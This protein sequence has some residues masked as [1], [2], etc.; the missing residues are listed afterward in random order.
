[1]PNVLQPARQ[2]TCT[3]ILM[4]LDSF[5]IHG[6]GGGSGAI[7]LDNVECSG[8]EERLENCNNSGTGVHDFDH[9]EDVAVTC[10]GKND[11]HACNKMCCTI[12]CM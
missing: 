1:M 4:I 7:F 11:I 10:L 3:G 12:K 2:D 5:A 8:L 6:F 9:T